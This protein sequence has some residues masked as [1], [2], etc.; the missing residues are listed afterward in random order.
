MNYQKPTFTWRRALLPTLILSLTLAPQAAWACA[1]CFGDPDSDLAKGA[2]RGVVFLA[3]VI[4][5]VL[6]SIAGIAT[7]WFVRARRLN[8]AEG[9]TPQ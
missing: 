7:S 3:V 2:V 1:V 9:G 8:R 6:V 4:G 5:G